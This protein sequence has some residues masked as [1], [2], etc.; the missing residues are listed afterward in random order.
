[1]SDTHAST[2]RE[3]S[4]AVVLSGEPPEQ[5][6]RVPLA[7]SGQRPNLAIVGRSTPI[8]ADAAAD[9][10]TPPRVCAGPLCT[11]SLDGRHVSARYCSPLCRSRAFRDHTRGLGPSATRYRARSDHVASQPDAAAPGT[12]TPEPGEPWWSA[13]F[14]GLVA[15]GLDDQAAYLWWHAHSTRPESL[16]SAGARA[17][18]DELG[19]GLDDDVARNG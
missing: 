5:P 15:E 9:E 1:M 16:P 13:R 2:A 3:L 17:L 4:T 10:P 8:A 11:T 19:L 14:R 12:P 6:A 7:R 18:A